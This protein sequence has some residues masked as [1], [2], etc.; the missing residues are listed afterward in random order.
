ML[1]VFL[2][3]TVA[4]AFKLSLRYVGYVHLLFYSSLTS[5]TVFFLILLFQG[6]LRLLRE[7][8]KSHFR[9]V[10]LGFLNPFLY[11][12]VLFKAYSLLPA[13]EAQALNYTWPIM[14]A[15]L[16][17]PLLKQR[18]TTKNIIGILTSFFGVLII[19]T[20]GDVFSL[21]FANPLGSLLALSSAIIWALY[22]IFNLRDERDD[23]LRMF[24]NFTFGFI[25]TAL[26]LMIFSGF[27]LSPLKGTIGSVYV[28]LFEMGITFLV[29]LKALRLSKTT[30]QIANL[31]YLTPFLSLVI[32]HF[33]VGEKILPSTLLGL[34]FIVGGIIIGR[35]K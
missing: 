4:S 13:Q 35:S 15:L 1:A 32:I 31:I 7:N 19:S 28:G 30:A 12:L 2:W 22:W 11:Y 34:G 23:L 10:I 27:Y 3:S 5:L 18:V 20:R 33:A 24:L 14:L 6:K 26:V 21:H 25:Y 9:S 17:I 16:S 29:W 8:P